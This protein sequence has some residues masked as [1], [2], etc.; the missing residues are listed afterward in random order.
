VAGKYSKPLSSSGASSA[1]SDP[2]PK[3]A[4]PPHRDGSPAK[5]VGKTA[6][7]AASPHRHE[8]PTA[9]GAHNYRTCSK[10]GTQDHWRRM[11]SEVIETPPIKGEGTM[12]EKEEVLEREKKGIYNKYLMTCVN[13]FAT[14]KGVELA[15]AERLIKAPRTESRIARADKYNYAK[16]NIQQFFDFTEEVVDKD[17]NLNKRGR[18]AVR[19]ALAEMKD[20]FQPMLKIL[21]LKAMDEEA[22][23]AAAKKYQAWVKENPGASDAEKGIKVD[24]ELDE[25]MNKWRAFASKGE[26]QAAFCRASDYADEWFGTINKKL[27]V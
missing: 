16:E 20:F 26:Q 17:G 23:L 12:A 19:V 8:A 18:I 27:R 4:V 1:N 11:K 24:E 2:T 7:G 10:C 9:V 13:C 14:E 6:T 25:A 22:A 3:P 5:G 21:A 15:A